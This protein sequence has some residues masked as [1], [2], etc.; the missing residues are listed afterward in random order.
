MYMNIQLYLAKQD[1]LS[2]EGGRTTHKQDTQGHVLCTCDF[3]LDLMTL[4]HKLNLDIL[5]M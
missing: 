2:I 3:E 4:I 1:S 5:T